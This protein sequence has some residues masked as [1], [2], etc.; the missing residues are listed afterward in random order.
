MKRLTKSLIIIF[1]A[2]IIILQIDGVYAMSRDEKISQLQKDGIVTGYPDGTLGLDKPIKRSEIAVLL[3]RLADADKLVSKKQIYKDV[4][5]KYWANGYIRV[6]T[7]TK[8]K[9]GVYLIAG[10][11]D[12]TFRPEKNISNAE[13][14]KIAVTAG[15][16][17]LHQT[18]V[19]NATWPD[20]WI[21]WAYET[22]IV[23]E[24]SG[25][26]DLDPKAS[27]TRGDVF[28][29]FYN[30]REKLLST[31]AYEEKKDTTI[32][33]IEDPNQDID[34][35][36][37][38][39]DATEGKKDPVKYNKEQQIKDDQNLIN[40]FNRME[41]YDRVA[42]ENEFL[43]LI[44][45]DRAKLGR[46]PVE[47]GTDLAQGGIARC[48]ELASYGSIV[49]NGRGHVRLDGSKWDTAFEYLQPQF[50]YTARGE[51]LLEVTNSSSGKMGD[52]SR[53]LLTD[54]VYLA[55]EFYRMWWNS[56]GHRDNM[57]YPK[58]K[59]IYVEARA[60][61]HS[62]QPN[63]LKNTVYIVGTTNFRGEYK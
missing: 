15:D 47:W 22:G 3:V 27:A 55:Q 62:R 52:R 49:V 14:M 9:N 24:G 21:G 60:S 11:P 4:S 33:K 19:D 42:F 2:A 1:L 6:C 13:M 32:E 8:S 38:N 30:S 17:R 23:G 29:M 46:D 20:S 57:M 7:H 44:N 58:F 18:D 10:Y 53:R 37:E 12:G 45:E 56:P 35:F 63:L 59:Y 5:L 26:N 36:K 25:V 48:E 40:A 28:V 39:K 31:M 50:S 41:S 43:R 34:S 61:N 16:R 51:N 54:G